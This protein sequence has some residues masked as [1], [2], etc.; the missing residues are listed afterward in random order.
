MN[1]TLVSDIKNDFVIR[2]MK[3]TVQREC[4]LDDAQ[5]GCEMSAV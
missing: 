3:H 4:Q 5:V 1:I 2:H